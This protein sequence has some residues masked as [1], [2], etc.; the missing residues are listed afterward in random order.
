MRKQPKEKDINLFQISKKGKQKKRRTMLILANSVLGVI[1]AISVLATSVMGAYV[2]G[3][4][5]MSLGNTSGQHEE[6]PGIY[7]ELYVSTSEDV[8]YILVVGEGWA[9]DGSEKLSDVIMVACVDHK[10]QTLNMVQIP[11][12]MFIGTDVPTYK[13]NAV[14]AYPRSGESNVNA[15]RRRLASHL[16]IPLDHYITFTL[17]GF[18]DAVDAIGGVDFVVTAENGLKI[19]DQDNI[20]TFYTIGP[21]EVHLDGNMA[22]GLVRKRYGTKEEGYRLGDPD[23]MKMQRTF[24]AALLKKLQNTSVAQLSNLVAKCYNYFSTDL[25]VNSLL[26]YALEIKNIGFDQ[27]SI[28]PIAGQYVQY[29]PSNYHSKLSYY[30]IHKED[31][32]ELFNTYLNPYGETLTVDDIRIREL[33]TELGIAKETAWGDQGGT[34]SEIIDKTGQ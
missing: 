28:H 25:D 4:S 29:K 11:R 6:E 24:Y 12:D 33:H 17:K 14:Y 27:I 32:V 8:S 23:R 21:G 18:R 7:E 34:A 16:G 9:A 13:T 10:A 22:T 1:L 19:E 31:Y 30:S 26:G 5:G 15:L 20:G 2:F 3:I